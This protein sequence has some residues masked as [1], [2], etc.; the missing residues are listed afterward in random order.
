MSNKNPV[1]TLIQKALHQASTRNLVQ[2]FTQTVRF[3]GRKY[4]LKLKR[5]FRPRGVSICHRDNCNAGDDCCHLGHVLGIDICY[6][7]SSQWDVMDDEIG[8][9]FSDMSGSEEED[10][11]DKVDRVL[12]VLQR[13]VEPLI[14]EK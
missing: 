5:R 10:A 12:Q 8:V 1:N 4:E 11:W 6:Y 9:I 7:G 2:G 3:N 13:Q 14:E